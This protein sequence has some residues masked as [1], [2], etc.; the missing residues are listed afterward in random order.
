MP[1]ESGSEVT[2]Q[3]T[4]QLPRVTPSRATSPEP[5]AKDSVAGADTESS[6]APYPVKWSTALE[7]PSLDQVDEKLRAESGFGVLDYGGQLVESKNCLEWTE[8]H[9]KGAAP[10][11]ARGS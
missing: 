7:L 11:T 4:D 9:R 3:S 6:K 2:K 1:A 5:T 8:L 10:P